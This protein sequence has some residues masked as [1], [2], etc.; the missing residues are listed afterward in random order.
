MT[1]SDLDRLVGLAFWTLGVLCL[2]NATGLADMGLGPTRAASAL[3]LLCCVL[4]LAGL[5]RTGPR[6]ALGVPGLLLLACL[7]S[8][9]GVGIVVAILTG[10][11]SLAMRYLKDGLFSILVIT[12]A[13][14]GGRVAWRRLGGERV[15]MGVLLILAA[16]CTLMLASPWLW[17][18]IPNPPR[19]GVYRFFAPYANP[20][21]AAVIASFTVVTAMA[22]LRSGRHQVLMYGVLL[23]GVVAVVGT[24]SRTAI[25]ALPIVLLSALF[26][27]RGAQRRRLLAA[28]AIVAVV[29]TGV[30]M[31]IGVGMLAEPQIARFRTL[32]ELVPPVVINDVSL[33]GRISLFELGLDQ[34]LESPL[35]G[36][37]LGHLHHLDEAWYNEHGSLMGVH[38]QYLVLIG[39]AGVLPLILFV[40]FLVVA[41]H[42][43]FRSERGW[44]LGAVSGC[45]VVL[46]LFSLASQSLLLHWEVNF[47]IGLSCAVMTGYLAD[48]RELA[49]AIPAS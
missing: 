25:I 38:N 36:S 11:E 47:I 41:V 18:I 34:T 1:D 37:G 29:G 10:T 17:E 27:A 24:I 43:G 14:V 30:A 35:V 42:A 7:L 46:S 48:Q 8:Y 39:E 3:T 2:L 26:S 40:S 28:L 49:G 6:E 23:V 16:S 20:N 12:A 31:N 19:E 33:A 21:Q 32:T 15:L 9:V 4:A 22:F 5:L 13:A 45:A 44:P